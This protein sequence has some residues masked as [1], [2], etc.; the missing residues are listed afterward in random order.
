MRTRSLLLSIA[1]A[2]SICVT[3]A[4]AAGPPAGVPMGPPASVTMGPPASVTM[5]PPASVTMGPPS[6]VTMGPPAGVTMGPPAGVTMGPPAAAM[7]HIP[8]GVPLGRPADVSNMG[9][10]ASSGDTIGSTVS[11]SASANGQNQE[12]SSSANAADAQAA[13]IL[14]NLNAAHASSTAFAHASSKSI[15]GEIA[16]YKTAMEAALSETDTTQQAADITAAREQLATES[17]KQLTPDAVSKVDSLLGITG[18]DPTL[19]TTT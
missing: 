13:N 15:V 17:N 7:A 8:N 16:A 12:A 9:T 3:P 1:G 19:G 14:G 2:A 4:V 10:N 18:A 11:A 5:G 6:S